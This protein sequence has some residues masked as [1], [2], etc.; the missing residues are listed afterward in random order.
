MEWSSMV[1][2]SMYIT[3]MCTV[4]HCAVYGSTVYCGTVVLCTVVLYD[5]IPTSAMYYDVS[6]VGCMYSYDMFA[7]CIHQQ[8]QFVYMQPIEHMRYARAQSTC[9]SH[10][11]P[12][13]TVLQ[14]PQYHS[15][16]AQYV[17]I[18]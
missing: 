1:H 10:T 14:S 8:H 13:H 6:Y 15:T 7:C 4:M 16:H 5:C 18:Q 17:H 9:V 3:S 11:A 2:A 12:Q